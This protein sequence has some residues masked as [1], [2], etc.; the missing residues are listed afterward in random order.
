AE[1]RSGANVGIREHRRADLTTNARVC[2]HAE[3]SPH[4]AET[5]FLYCSRAASIGLGTGYPLNTA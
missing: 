5:P 3:A 1:H 2:R 4:K